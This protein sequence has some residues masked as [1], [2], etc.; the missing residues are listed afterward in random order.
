[1]SKKEDSLVVELN[2]DR[3]NYAT[4]VL[5]NAEDFV[6][7]QNYHRGRLARALGYL[8]GYGTVSGLRVEYEPAT[9]ALEELAALSA[10]NSTTIF[11]EN[12]LGQP[13]GTVALGEQSTAVMKKRDSHDEMPGSSE[14]RIIVK[15]GLSIDRHGRLIEMSKPY[16]LR[17]N[18]WFESQDAEKLENAR[19]EAAINAVVVDLFIRFVT[20]EHGKTPAFANGPFNSL[21]AVTAARLRDHF[22][23][24]TVLRPNNLPLPIP[25]P[26]WESITNEPSG[27]RQDVLNESILNSWR[28]GTEFNNESGLNPLVEHAGVADTS[29]LL[30]ARIQI[31]AI[32]GEGSGTGVDTPRP[33]RTEDPVIVDNYLRHFVYAAGALAQWMDK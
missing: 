8:H 21:D 22:E 30:L 3:V 12:A 26:L 6:A 9:P 2:S 13:L 28:E 7:E 1:M 27:T 14:E 15:P 4:G 18:R 16:C 25:E 31:P 24:F 29:S 23:L 5:L 17:L 32:R 33:I 10:V 19:H 11:P 20:C